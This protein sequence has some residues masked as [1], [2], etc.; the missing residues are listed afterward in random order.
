MPV[1]ESLRCSRQAQL[2]A[3]PH[4]LR[5]LQHHPSLLRRVQSRRPHH[6]STWRGSMGSWACWVP[7]LLRIECRA[8]VRSDLPL[9]RYQNDDDEHQHRYYCS[10]TY[11]GS[12]ATV[13]IRHFGFLCLGLATL[14]R[15][16]FCYFRAEV[17][18]WLDLCYHLA[19]LSQ[20]CDLHLCVL[21]SAWFSPSQTIQLPL[22]YQGAQTRA[23][24]RQARWA[25]CASVEQNFALQRGSCPTRG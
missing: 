15:H 6:G 9:S 16:C 25:T 1:A 8:T 21:Q 10:N 7:G 17:D 19:Y 22:S 24:L 5:S 2:A 18:F 20:Q 23:P 11:F 12:C 4:F 13:Q 3:P 14:L